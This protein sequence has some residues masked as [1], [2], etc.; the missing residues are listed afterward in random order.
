LYKCASPICSL[1]L[2]FG[3]DWPTGDDF[4]YKRLRG[5]PEPNAAERFNNYLGKM[6]PEYFIIH[7]KW[8]LE[9]QS[10]LQELLNDRF[11]ILRNIQDYLIYKKKVKD[12]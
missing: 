10:D 3:K 6:S 9:E 11:F 7:D 8:L 12:T 4:W 2:F 5:I 1:L